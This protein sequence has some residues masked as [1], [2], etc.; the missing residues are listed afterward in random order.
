MLVFAGFGINVVFAGQNN[1]ITTF[2]NE[3]H[4]KQHSDE[5]VCGKG[6]F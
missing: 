4:C 6:G 2:L 5:Y 3:V 1:G